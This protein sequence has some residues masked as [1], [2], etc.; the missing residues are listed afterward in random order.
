MIFRKLIPLLAALALSGCGAPK[1]APKEAAQEFFTQCASGKIGDAYDSSSNLFKL[2]RTKQYFEARVHDTGLD[3]MKSVEWSEPES[4]DD[5]VSIKGNFE[6]A[7]GPM[8][9]LVTLAQESGRW[10]LL[11]AKSEGEKGDVF[12]VQTRSK[13]NQ[14]E[15]DKAFGEPVAIAMPSDRQLQQLVEGTIMEFQSALTETEKP[16]QKFF[17][18]VSDRWKYRGKDP[19]QLNYVG[20]D[21]NRLAQSDPNNTAQRLTI[22][23]LRANF[24]PFVEARVDLSPI[25]GKP[26]TFTTPPR[27]TSDGVLILMGEYKEFVFQGGFPP[28]PRTLKFQL[29][30]VF[31]GSS[32]RL[33]GITLQLERPPGTE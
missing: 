9:L 16:F 8:T 15:R 31:E 20:T 21:P 27:L 17:D 6:T 25:K 30:Y 22:E 29:E 11:G 19:S 28:K 7:K 5:T 2:E 32:W 10:R 26:A 12:S 3:Q 14:G 4:K 24:R 33:F 1:Q 18:T 13:D 23:A